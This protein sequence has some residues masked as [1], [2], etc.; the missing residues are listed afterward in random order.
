MLRGDPG[1]CRHVR[2]V[3]RVGSGAV[4]GHAL[5]LLFRDPREAIR[6]IGIVDDVFASIAGN[7]DE[8]TRTVERDVVLLE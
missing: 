1:I 7:G 2:G 4:G 8:R 3:D 5:A 6:H